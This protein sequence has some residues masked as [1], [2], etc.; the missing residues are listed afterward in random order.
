[1]LGGDRWLGVTVEAR[2]LSRHLQAER[3][4]VEVEREG[5]SLLLAGTAEGYVV[6]LGALTGE[7]VFSVQAHES[8]VVAITCNPKR[9]HVVSHGTGN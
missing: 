2:K 3:D 8:E 6:T 5:W 9:N 4:P 7:V 1:M